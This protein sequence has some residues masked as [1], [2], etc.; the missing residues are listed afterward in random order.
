MKKI[1]I[2]FFVFSVF[3]LQAQ[4]YLINFS[5]TGASSAVETIK[6]ENLTQGKSISLSGSEILHLKDKVTANS[7]YLENGNYG[8]RVF[9]NPTNRDCTIDC[10]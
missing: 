5:G 8:L 3:R 4:D 1:I 2:L 10:K 9:P 7:P 6:V